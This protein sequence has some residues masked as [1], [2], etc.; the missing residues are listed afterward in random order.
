MS[1]W[2]LIKFCRS[3]S[4]SIEPSSRSMA[5]LIKFGMFRI[6]EPATSFFSYFDLQHLEHCL[7]YTRDFMIYTWISLCSQF[8]NYSKF[9]E[10]NKGNFIEQDKN[11]YQHCMKVE[12]NV[13]QPED[14]RSVYL[15]VE[16][17]ISM[18]VRP[19]FHM[20]NGPITT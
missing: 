14:F 9:L 18:L 4:R 13:T 15:S 5:Q 11:V 8:T 12:S 20:C 7:I 6:P 19:D 10:P 2:T 17:I 3:V 16:S 1:C